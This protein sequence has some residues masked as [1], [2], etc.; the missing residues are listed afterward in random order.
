MIT[1]RG[2]GY[3]IMVL[4][5]TKDGRIIAESLYEKGLPVF[6]NN[7]N[8]NMEEDCLNRV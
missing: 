5:G 1:P 7:S 2:Y 6:S 4:A 8:R 3:M